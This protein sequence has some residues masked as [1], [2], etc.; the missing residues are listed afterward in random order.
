VTGKIVITMSNVCW[1][2]CPLCRDALFVC[3]EHPAE[4]WPHDDCPVPGV[5]CPACQDP[6]E[7]RELPRNYQSLAS[8]QSHE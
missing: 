4:P 5:P 1:M 2:P 8:T 6:H 3:E 7:R